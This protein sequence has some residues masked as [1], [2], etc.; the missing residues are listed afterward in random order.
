MK[1]RIIVAVTGASG[2]IYARQTIEELKR[3]PQVAE[4]ALIVSRNGAAV[5]AFEGEEILFD[6]ERL[7]VYDN[8]DMFAPTAS[9]SS[10]FDSMVVVPCSM[11]TVGRIASGVSSDLISRSADVMLKERRRLILVPRE[12]PFNLIHLQNMTAVT[13]AG[14]VVLPAM[15]SFYSSPADVESLCSTVTERIMDLLDI[16]TKHFRW[17]V[18]TEQADD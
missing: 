1:R 13:Q 12:T 15:P 17:A 5:M 4:I 2:A 18:A 7:S 16:P 10:M 6:D 3:S 9:G 8:E 14:A 11:G